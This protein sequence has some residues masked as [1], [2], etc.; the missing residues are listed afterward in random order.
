MLRKIFGKK[1]ADAALVS[2]H[3]ADDPDA[4]IELTMDE[5]GRYAHALA[6][7]RGYPADTA[8]MIARRVVFLERRGIIGFVA[9]VREIL[10]HNEEWLPGRL[11]GRTRDNQ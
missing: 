1:P 6:L 7:R 2:P 10:L 11:G 5:V 3:H 9:L 4:R 8:G